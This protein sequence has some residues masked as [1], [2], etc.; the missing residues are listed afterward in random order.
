M[1][2]HL[3]LVYSAPPELTDTL[4]E[5]YFT[6]AERVAGYWREIAQTEH[7]LAN[8]KQKLKVEEA[9]MREVWVLAQERDAETA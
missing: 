7:H 1:E 3:R 9:K 2:N 8:L 4:Q 5:Q 6:H